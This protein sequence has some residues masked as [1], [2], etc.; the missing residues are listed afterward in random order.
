MVN[1]HELAMHSYVGGGEDWRL[2]RNWPLL[3][4]VPPHT[5]A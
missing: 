5:M 1:S 3:A 2:S 4:W